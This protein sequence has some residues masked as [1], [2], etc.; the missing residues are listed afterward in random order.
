[1]NPPTLPIRDKMIKTNAPNST[2]LRL[3]I[4]VTAIVWTFSVRVEDPVPVPQRPAKT[5]Q[6]PSIPIPRLRTPGVGGL[7]ATNKDDAWY[8][9]TES[10][11]AIMETK[12]ITRAIFQLNTGVPHCNG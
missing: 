4:L 7:D 5:L 6:R 9:P 1:M 11:H 12:H 2:A 10:T 8:E 3:P